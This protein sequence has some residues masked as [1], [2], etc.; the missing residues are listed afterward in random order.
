MP[1]SKNQLRRHGDTTTSSEQDL[2]IF[3]DSKRAGLE[4][5]PR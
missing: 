5:L 3:D 4:K 1:P 2:K